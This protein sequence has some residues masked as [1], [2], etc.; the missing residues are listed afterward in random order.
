MIF[1]SVRHVQTVAPH[2]KIA[3]TDVNLEVLRTCVLP[4]LKKGFV[5]FIIACVS[6]KPRCIHTYIGIYNTCVHTY[7][8]GLY[9]LK[10]LVW[11]LGLKF[12]GNGNDK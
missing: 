4:C 2:V 10:R 1:G 6:I 5:Y 11:L 9:T 12:R 7:C 3:K 8:L